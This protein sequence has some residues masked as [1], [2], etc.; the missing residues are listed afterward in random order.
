M[1]RQALITGATGLVGSHLTEQLA[2]DG[3]T[4]RALVRDPRSAAWIRAL[5]ASDLARGDVLDPARRLLLCARTLLVLETG[6]NLL[7]LRTLERM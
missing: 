7:G 2:T 6:L 5:G 4:V 1:T 3:W